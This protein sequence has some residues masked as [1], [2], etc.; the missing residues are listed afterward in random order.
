MPTRLCR[1]RRQP[2]PRILTLA[3]VSVTGRRLALGFLLSISVAGCG[4]GT[5][6][7]SAQR[8]PGRLVAEARPIGRSARF[9]PPAGRRIIGRCTP[10]LGPRNGVHVEVFAANRVVLLPAGISAHGSFT[11]LSGRIVR[12][13]CY[14]ALVTLDPTGLVLVRRGVSLSVG[15]LFRAWG[16]QLSPRH[17]A[18][19]TSPSGQRVVIYVN[20][21]RWTGPLASVPLKRHDE[22]VL[23]AGPHVPPHASYTFPPGL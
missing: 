5:V 8:I 22:I 19:F 14:G 2:R 15:D 1:C 18:S 21:R 7:T 11:Y 12:A 10:R 13:R 16:Q 9:H 23:E 3:A 20:G 17:L 4:A 6:P